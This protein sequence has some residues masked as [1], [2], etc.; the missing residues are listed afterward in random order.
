MNLS[1]FLVR[2][3]KKVFLALILALVLAS[4]LGMYNKSVAWDERCYIGLGLYLFKTGNFQIDGFIYH[5]PLSYYLNS[6]FLAPLK[7]KTDAWGKNNCWDIGNSM[8]FHSNYSHKAIVFLSRIPFVL[9]AVLLGFFVF[10]WAKELY[11]S[12]AGLLSLA[13][14]SFSPSIIANS[15]VAMTDFASVAFMF[16]ALYYFWKYIRHQ[17]NI[18]VISTGVFVGLSSLSKV[19]G[20][21]I[22]PVLFVLSLS[23]DAKLLLKRMAKIIVIG[24]IAFF[25]IFSGY[26]FSV[27]TAASAYPEH[28]NSRVHSIIDEKFKDSESARNALYFLYERIKLPAPTYMAMVGDVAFSSVEGRNG[29]LFGEISEP[30]A[31]WWYYFIVVF[32]AKSTLGFL[33]LLILSLACFR[34]CGKKLADEMFLIV[35]S[36]FIFVV[37]SLNRFSFDLRHILIA[38]PLMFVFVGRLANLRIKNKKLGCA[39]V[40]LPLLLHI[41]SSLLAFPNYS[42]YFNE[43][44]GQGNGYRV[45]LGPDVDT[46]SELISLKKYMDA[47]GIKNIYFSYHGSVDPKEY[48]ISYAYL[49]STHFQFWVPEYRPYKKDYGDVFEDCSR[50]R[51][52]VA[53]SVTSL[54]GRFL[55][56]HDCFGW[57]EN[58]Q[59][60]AKIG[61]SI[62]VY[63]TL[64]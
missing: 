8:V 39:I 1:K 49:P 60:V 11:G 40:A 27:G 28:Y 37:F 45:L 14:Y 18:Y 35:P 26:G 33:S 13:L 16:I 6:L 57:L 9:I 17:K 4:A 62:F 63:N 29:Y 30:G 5:A 41:S 44:I 48:G 52:W 24:I 19:S 56:N 61:N 43:I 25:I 22:F 42:S 21:Y 23:K 46:G 32:F 20:L 31:K 47:N 38:Y 12:L 53:V 3:E 10:R 58:E 34:K 55:N 59:P 50:K 36:I 2:N 54:K 15:T 64:K 51:G 7:I